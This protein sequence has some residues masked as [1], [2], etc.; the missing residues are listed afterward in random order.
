MDS[1]SEV[2]ITQHFLITRFN[3]RLGN[4]KADRDLRP[5]LTEEWMAERLDLFEQVCVPSVQHQTNQE[6]VWLLLLD[7]ETAP[8]TVGRIE[9]AVAGVT[10]V[11]MVFLPE[12]SDDST[13]AAAVRE[14]VDDDTGL[15]LTTRLDNDDAL[16][17]DALAVVRRSTRPGRREFLNLRFGWVTDGELARVK[18]HKYGHFTTL[19]EPRG[20]GVGGAGEA[21]EFRTVHCGLAHGRVRRFA[22]VRQIRGGPYWLE[23]V[24]RRNVSNRMVREPRAHSFGSP[25]AVHRWFRYEIVAPIRRLAWPRRF[26]GDHALSDISDPFNIRWKSAQAYQAQGAP[27]GV[28]SPSSSKSDRSNCF[29]KSDFGAK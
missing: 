18:A 28:D 7:D 1:T 4:V 17:E 13:I 10:D 11:E 29:R 14:R 9:R 16:H 6:F 27:V 23:V 15:L 25:L 3:L 2:T 21:V 26:R 8:E 5:V 20:V 24:H 12:G 19:V 22:P